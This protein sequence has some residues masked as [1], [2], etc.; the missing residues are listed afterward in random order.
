MEKKYTM[1]EFKQMFEDAQLK[2]LQNSITN[3]EIEDIRKNNKDISEKTL[4]NFKT[5]QI[6]STM[7]ITSKLFNEIFKEEK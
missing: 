7:M 5:H 2:L 6:L 1:S 3:E 4:N